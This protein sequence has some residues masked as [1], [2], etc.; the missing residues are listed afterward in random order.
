MATNSLTLNIY[1][2]AAGAT[3]ALRSVTTHLDAMNKATAASSG[4]TS[5]L[6]GSFTSLI[7]KVG[8]FGLA[9]QGLQK[10]V[11]MGKNLVDIYEEYEYTLLRA[12]ATLKASGE[13]NE[14]SFAKVTDEVRRLGSTTMFHARDAAEGLL[15]LSQA[16]YSAE[17]SMASLGTALNLAQAGNLSLDKATSILVSTIA[18][19]GGSASEAARYSDVLAA[20]ASASLADVD[21]LAEGMKYAGVY[22]GQLGLTVEETAAALA[23]L[24]QR[25]LSNT[26]GGAALDR[27]FVELSSQSRPAIKRLMALKEA[28]TFDKLD[29]RRNTLAEVLQNLKDAG[30]TGQDLFAVMEARGARAGAILLSSLDNAKAGLKS[31]TKVTEN[32]TGVTDTMAGVIGTSW[33]AISHR[34]RSA[35][36]ELNI[37]IGESLIP[38]LKVQADNLSAS[39]LGAADTIRI[40]KAAMA[41]GEG[42]DFFMSAIRLGAMK[43]LNFLVGYGLQSFNV[44]KAALSA[45]FVSIGG[46]AEFFKEFGGGFI[47]V[48]AAGGKA[49]TSA[50]VNAGATFIGYMRAHMEALFSMDT[51][52]GGAASSI[53]NAMNKWA[54]GIGAKFAEVRGDTNTQADYLEKIDK[55]NQWQNR[56]KPD[57]DTVTSEKAKQYA[58]ELRTQ[59]DSSIEKAQE[60]AEAG[61]LRIQTAIENMGKNVNGDEINAAWAKVGDEIAKMGTVEIFDE[62]KVQAEF[63]AFWEKYKHKLPNMEKPTIKTPPKPDPRKKGDLDDPIAQK[64]EGTGRDGEAAIAD[65]LQQIGGGGGS[66][67]YGNST[68]ESISSNVSKIADI[69]DDSESDIKKMEF[70]N[71]TSEEPLVGKALVTAV[72]DFNRTMNSMNGPTSFS[73]DD[74]SKTFVAEFNRAEPFVKSNSL[75]ESINGVLEDIR[76]QGRNTRGTAI[77]VTIK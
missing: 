66:Y 11:S 51:G 13:Y 16:G 72:D 77:P 25:N 42:G 44:L 56:P 14:Q 26:L 75:L 74:L 33:K 76:E 27:F 43:G 46:N 53:G 40:F 18:Q 65:S 71:K 47:D 61:I 73:P 49:L 30:V 31:F 45:V 41:G 5:A 10:G 58:D 59:A 50:L 7:A 19:F 34:V 29:L 62:S 48:V 20:A 2:N 35:W 52:L 6:S 4:T 39:L 1:G 8:A 54:Y 70:D 15:Y 17:E 37:T 23:V 67:G 36:E 55:I 9:Y 21:S 3:A 69:M 12:K 60:E 57:A 32:A 28:L 22:A 24:S 68:M 38:M 63:D 64:K